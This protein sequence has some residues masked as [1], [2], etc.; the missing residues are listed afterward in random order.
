MAGTVL[1]WV[2]ETVKIE[3]AFAYFLIATV[4]K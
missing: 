2:T 3:S 1:I 4:M